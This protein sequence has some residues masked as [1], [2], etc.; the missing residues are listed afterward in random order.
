[1]FFFIDVGERLEE[2]TIIPRFYSKFFQ[3]STANSEMRDL[4]PIYPGR[5]SGK[6]K[7]K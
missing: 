6:E 7:L 3:R 1:M 4:A 2:I 5:E